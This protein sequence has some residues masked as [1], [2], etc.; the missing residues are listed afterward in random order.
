MAERLGR[1]EPNHERQRTARAAAVES[2][3]STSAPPASEMLRLQ[4]QAG[5]QATIA[6]LARSTTTAR[7]PV[8]A[9]QREP[10]KPSLD[11]R[12]ADL[13]KARAADRARSNALAIDVKWRAKFGERRASYQQAIYRITNGIDQA[14]A[15]FQTAQSAQAQTDAM[16]AQV[17]GLVIAVGTAGAFEPLAMAGLGALGK[18][19]TT[20]GLRA[21]RIKK[22]VETAENPAVAA[23]G[24]YVTNIRGNQVANASSKAGQVPE[25]PSNNDLGVK[26][27]GA[28]VDQT[29]VGFLTSNLESL[30][31]Y[32]REVEASFS[33]RATSL[34]AMSDDDVAKFD[35]AGTEAE[36]Q[37]LF[38]EI[39]S[40]CSGAE[41][42]LS[43]GEI[44]KIYERYMWAAWILRES[45]AAAGI[46]KMRRDVGAAQGGKSPTAPQ[47]A[48][49]YKYDVGTDIEDRL[50]AIGISGLAKVTLTGHWYSPNSS[51][52][53]QALLGWARGYRESIAL[54]K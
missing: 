18:K 39:S 32:E 44:A 13:E 6:M 34:A 29:A 33:D 35:A 45:A 51:G 31:G 10:P 12:V 49:D 22:I 25:A 14:T 11:S 36:Y 41:E 19:F 42:L 50:N 17:I 15:G 38:T 24:G 28:A 43:A 54:S 52:W 30:A 8:S 48:D 40:I 7:G 53:Q 27:P 1:E 20:L 47:A 5:N 3:S 16:K 46:A 26:T 37:Q 9:I 21:R 2:R 23:V 4:K